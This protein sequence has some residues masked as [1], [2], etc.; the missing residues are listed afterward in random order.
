MQAHNTKGI[1]LRTV[2]YGETSLIATVFTELFG[3]QSYMVKG[4]RQT[5]KK[6][7]TKANFFQP[8]AI[9]EMA[10]Y[11][12]EL[13]NLQFVESYYWH[14]LYKNIYF[15]VVK[16]TVAS[17]MVELLQLALKQPETNEELYYFIQENLQYLD[18]ANA[19]ATANM[20]IYFTLQLAA[21]L[22]FQTQGKY[23]EN[24][25]YF[26]IQEGSF[27]TVE[28]L[29]EHYIVGNLASI[30]SQMAKPNSHHAISNIQI[31]NQDRNYLLQ[32]YI[33][34][35]SI[36]VSNFGSLKTLPILQQILH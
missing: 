7:T 19:T 33:L 15:N 8:A 34:Y 24:T 29:H 23:S 26:D 4:V 28:P 10:V 11:N 25:K 17:F 5:T 1:V 3:K 27:T 18:E 12:N 35:F 6:G 9:L 21:Y 30:T 22:G 36:H 31:S 20:P 32:Q 2:K 13:K 14:Y 16:N